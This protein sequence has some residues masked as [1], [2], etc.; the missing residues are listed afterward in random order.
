LIVTMGEPAGIGPDILLAA[1]QHLH[2]DP[3]AC[4]AV[5]GDAE[6]LAQRV[7][8][9]GA[10]SLVEKIDTMKHV[11]EHFSSALPVLHRPLIRRPVAG[12]ISPENAGW[13]TR[14]IEEAVQLVMDQTASGVVTC[15]IQ[16]E[17]LYQAGFAFEGHTDFL[18]ELARRGGHDATPVMLLV[19]GG[20]RTVPITVHIPLK[21]VPAKLTHDAI[22][23]Q[24]RITAR[25]L[26]SRFGIVRPRIGMTGLNPHAGEGGTMGN[27][28]ITTI[29]PAIRA[30]QAEGL[31]VTGPLPGDTAFH[32]EARSRYD[33]IMCMYHD[34]ALIPVKTLDFHGGVNVTLGLPFIRTSPDH[35][36]ALN[37][38][39]TGK[40]NPRSLIAAIR[41]AAEMASRMNT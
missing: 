29:I 18:A 17:A 23:E 40:A 16:K 9:V 27:E 35:G 36:T 37:L 20:L 33:V 26:A 31:N 39:G 3:S 12:S 24:T 32:E 7:G 38:A 10:V 1:W 4:F 34:Q 22:M 25:D 8:Q 11:A 19:A 14:L 13:V 30:L 2:D 6:L 28:E 41:L 5:L 15:P 21:H